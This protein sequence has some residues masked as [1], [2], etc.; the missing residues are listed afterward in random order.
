MAAFPL[1]EAK[2]L[3]YVVR[4]HHVSILGDSSGLRH[5]HG[6]H[7]HKIKSVKI[8]GFTSS[9]SLVELTCHVVF[10][11]CART[12]HVVEN[13]K[14][15][16]LLTLEAHQSSLKCSVPDHNCSKCSPLPIGS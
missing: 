14:S 1:A 6:Q 7:H 3:R 10:F 2:N 5:L 11:F 15:R 16:E 8:L 12:C 13:I 4:P 9:K